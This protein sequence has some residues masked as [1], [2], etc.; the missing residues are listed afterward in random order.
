MDDDLES[1]RC[2]VK[3]PDYCNW[4]EHEFMWSILVFGGV[5]TTL[6]IQKS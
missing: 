6:N 4:S 5:K 2:N 1:H 3:Q